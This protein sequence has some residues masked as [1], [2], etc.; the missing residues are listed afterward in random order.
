M[1]AKLRTNETHIL[2][3]VI[4]WCARNRAFDFQGRCPWL[5]IFNPYRVFILVS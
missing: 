1:S 3:N 4:T 2:I 5:Q